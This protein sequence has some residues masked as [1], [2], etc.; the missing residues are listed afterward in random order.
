MIA[1]CSCGGVEVEATGPPIGCFVCYCDDCQEGSRRAEALPNATPVRE[2]D[3]G[4]AYVLYRKDRVTVTSGNERL[5]DHKIRVNSATNRTIA[6]CCHS[7]MLMRFDDARHWVPIY[8]AGFQGD[9]PPVEMRICTK[10]RSADVHLPDD[11]PNHKGF[12]FGFLAKLLA[13][14]LAMLVGR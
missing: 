8:R 13:A 11:V 4:T 14:R 1:R 7:A 6:S 3:G 12:P 5:E 9:V 2:P 10:F